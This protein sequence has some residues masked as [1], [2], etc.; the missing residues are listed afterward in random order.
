MPKTEKICKLNCRD[1]EKNPDAIFKI[2]N[3]P[4]FICSKC[5]RVAKNK[6]YLCKPVA[7]SEK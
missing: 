1:F 5:L 3:K 4:K 6:K 2:V 7:L